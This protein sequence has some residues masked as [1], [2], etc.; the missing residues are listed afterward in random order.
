M[1]LKHYKEVIYSVE[2]KDFDSFVNSIYGGNFSFVAQYSATN[3]AEHHF[4]L[5]SELTNLFGVSGYEAEEIRR[6]EYK[7]HLVGKVFQCLF[8]DGHL[9]E[10]RYI[11]SVEY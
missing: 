10:G 5:P 8:E 9:E 2:D 4:V 6:G 1:K 7:D 3:G 11:I